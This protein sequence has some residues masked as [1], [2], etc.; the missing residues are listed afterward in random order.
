MMH[1]HNKMIQVVMHEYE[2]KMKKKSIAEKAMGNGQWAAYSGV[3][4]G[5]W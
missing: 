4:L 1:G 2:I 5:M 3:V